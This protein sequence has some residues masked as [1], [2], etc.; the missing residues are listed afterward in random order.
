MV[1][2]CSTR[3]VFVW[4]YVAVPTR[5]VEREPEWVSHP[6]LVVAEP[7]TDV[8]KAKRA[9]REGSCRRG[10][11]DEANEQSEGRKWDCTR[12]RSVWHDCGVHLYR[13]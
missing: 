13:A 4:A 6:S 2:F 11:C 9:M 3:R 1:D 7:D 12:E 5:D 10:C 8:P